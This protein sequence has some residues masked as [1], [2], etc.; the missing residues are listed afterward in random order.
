M[1]T[2]RHRWYGAVGPRSLRWRSASPA[3]REV[4]ESAPLLR[5]VLHRY[6]VWRHAYQDHL[7][8]QV[9]PSN[10][11]IDSAEVDTQARCSH[12]ASQTNRHARGVG[13]S[14][15]KAERAFIWHRETFGKHY[16]HIVFA[17]DLHPD[18]PPA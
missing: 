15:S 14:V 17:E 11:G 9:H 10:S 5:R 4:H 6:W 8:W 2:A 12:H 1:L 3:V 7:G 13:A 18:L 16:S